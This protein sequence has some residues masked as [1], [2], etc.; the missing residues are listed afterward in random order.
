MLVYFYSHEVV[1]QHDVCYCAKHTHHVD[2]DVTY[3]QRDDQNIAKRS[4]FV[5][6][7]HPCVRY[8]QLQVGAS[9]VHLM[10]YLRGVHLKIC[11]FFHSSES[12]CFFRAVGQSLGFSFSMNRAESAAHGWSRSE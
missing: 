5:L 6:C 3:Q 1:T 2:L 8:S 9:E 7:L 11:S 4:Q 10:L 12:N